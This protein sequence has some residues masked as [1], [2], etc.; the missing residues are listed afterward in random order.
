MRIKIFQIIS[1]MVAAVTISVMIGC[2]NATEEPVSSSEA[3]SSQAPSTDFAGGT[4]VIASWVDPEPKLGLSAGQDAQY[5]ALEQAKERYNCK[6]EYKINV[7]NDHVSKI[8]SNSLSGIVY[9]DI[10]MAHSWNHVG[11]INQD[12]LIQTDKYLEA[13]TEAER[14]HWT[15]DMCSLKGHY[16]GLHPKSDIV[17]PT[18]NLFYNRTILS[19]LG[20]QDPQELALQGAWNWDKFKE[21]CIAATDAAKNRYGAAIYNLDAV[22]G[23]A[24]GVQTV[25]YDETDKKYYNGFTH[26]DAKEKN[27][28]VVEFLQSLSQQGAMLGFWPQGAEAMDEA[29]NAM[30]D[31][32]VLFTFAQNG[33]R[34]K[35]FGMENFGVVTA[36]VADFN[37]SR[38][39]YNTTASYVYW[40]I[41]TKTTFPADDLAEFWIYANTTWDETR[42]DAY[43]EFDLDE[44]KEYL[45]STH[46][47]DMKDVDFL[48]A[49]KEGVVEI[50]SLDLAVS[51]G[52]LV[53]RDIFVEVISG[54]M[55]PSAAIATVDNQIQAKIDEA[56]N[57]N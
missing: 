24:N 27:L 7:L 50:P 23:G 42:G 34:L 6:I 5:Y 25:V 17:L 28:A 47:T 19:E 35:S 22:L 36:P 33:E 38:T 52:S 2:N 31:G 49:M 14:K 46:Y 16:Y 43:Y 51:L 30:L 37:T 44:Y 41:P 55:T 20:L 21:Y 32:Q 12:I 45:L 40:A 53:A 48:L 56:L 29:E 26:T 11:L 39:L 18:Q 3:S 1:I 15:T 8:I 57:T 54:N 10:F 4:I 9:A 13:M